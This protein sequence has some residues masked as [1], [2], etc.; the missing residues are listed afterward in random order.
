MSDLTE[1]WILEGRE[2]EGFD[3]WIKRSIDE[4]YQTY[5]RRNMQ[6]PYKGSKEEVLDKFTRT[7]MTKDAPEGL[8]EWYEAKLKEI[9][10]GN[11]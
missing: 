1:R 3:D 4:S 9:D 8:L 2:G 10:D 11:Q 6:G 7:L 5:R